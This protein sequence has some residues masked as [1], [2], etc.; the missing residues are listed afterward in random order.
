MTRIM[1]DETKKGMPLDQEIQYVLTACEVLKDAYIREV[2]EAINTYPEVEECAV[3][4]LTDSSQGEYAKAFIVLN[5]DR[6]CNANDI[7]QHLKQSLKDYT[8]PI[9]IEFKNTLPKT[10]TGKIKKRV[11]RG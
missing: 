8:F 11:L 1:D 3:I 5:D 10:P 4:I 7:L 9:K 2:E 6:K